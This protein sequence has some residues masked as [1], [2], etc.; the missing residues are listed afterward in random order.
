MQDTTYTEEGAI[1]VDD[2]AAAKQEAARGQVVHA[3]VEA[4]E[5]DGT[6]HARVHE[7]SVDEKEKQESV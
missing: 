2:V 7:R 3:H 5:A 1:F 4:V 6:H